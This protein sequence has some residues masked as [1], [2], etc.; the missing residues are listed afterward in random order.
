MKMAFQR[1]SDKSLPHSNGSWTHKRVPSGKWC[2]PEYA[3][4]FQ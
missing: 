1:I 2:N 4:Y 3:L